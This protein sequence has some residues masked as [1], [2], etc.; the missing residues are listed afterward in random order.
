MCYIH[1][2]QVCQHLSSKVLVGHHTIFCTTTVP[3]F[4]GDVD[5]DQNHKLCKEAALLSVTMLILCGLL[6][7]SH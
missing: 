5:F 3:Y 7:G 1:V 4:V 2:Q 6:L